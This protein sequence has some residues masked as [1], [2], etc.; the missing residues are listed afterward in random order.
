MSTLSRQRHRGCFERTLKEP[1]E[2][3]RHFARCQ[4]DPAVPDVGQGM[5]CAIGRMDGG[6]SGV[7]GRCGKRLMG[8]VLDEDMNRIGALR[9]KKGGN[10]RHRK[11]LEIKIRLCA[12][13]CRNAHKPKQGAK[14]A[15]GR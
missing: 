9:A 14:S 8:P 6:G 1:T 15:I 10:L 3:V 7:S 11:G 13:M 5:G 12:H 4:P 2:F